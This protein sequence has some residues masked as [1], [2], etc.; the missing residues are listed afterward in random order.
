MRH[1]RSRSALIRTTAPYSEGSVARF[2]KTHSAIAIC[3]VQALPP[4]AAE[5]EASKRSSG[6][7]RI[8]PHIQNTLCVHRGKN[9]PLLATNRKAL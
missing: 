5:A 2:G 8:F 1:D 7:R 6:G 9:S 4:H 3:P